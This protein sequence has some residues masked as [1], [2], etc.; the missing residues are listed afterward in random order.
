MVVALLV[1]LFMNKTLEYV[2]D[3]KQDKAVV[4]YPAGIA[5]KHDK[6]SFKISDL[7]HIKFKGAIGFSSQSSRSYSSLGFDFV[8]HTGRKIH[9]GIYSSSHKK[10]KGIV[11]ELSNFLEA[12]VVE[13]DGKTEILF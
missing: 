11:A 13:K 5:S 6:T 8:L 12:P 2:L 7:K 1:F 4:L 3:K 10:I 9:G